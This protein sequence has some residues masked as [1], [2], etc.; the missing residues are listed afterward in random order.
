M[1]H[2]LDSDTGAEFVYHLTAEDYEEAIIAR[3]RRSPGSL[4][5]WWLL[6]LSCSIGITLL[7]DLPA[8]GRICTLVAGVGAGYG[9]LVAQRR[10]KAR[11]AAAAVAESH[12]QFRVAA[13]DHG[14]VFSPS[15]RGPVATEWTHFHAY[16]ETPRLFVLLYGGRWTPTLIA[17]PKRGARSPGDV[18][19]LRALLDWKLTRL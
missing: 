15:A 1:R 13:G 8:Y 9:A 10:T 3:A 7:Y 19:R 12:G 4:I 14:V 16:L 17:L 18:E 6:M 2:E 5:C 11:K